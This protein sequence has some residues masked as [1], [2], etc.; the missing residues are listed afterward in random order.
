MIDHRVI[1]T[2]V[3]LLGL[4]CLTLVS[5]IL[6]GVIHGQAVGEGVVGM[7]SASIAS[8]AGLLSN[9]RRQDPPPPPTPPLTETP[10]A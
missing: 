3:V 7:T 5:G 10:K 9:L 2:V 6:Y 1:L 8:L 4:I